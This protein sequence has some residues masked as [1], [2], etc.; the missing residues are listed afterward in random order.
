MHET[1]EM[2][3]LKIRGGRANLLLLTQERNG[4]VLLR[5]GFKDRVAAIRAKARVD[6]PKVGDISRSQASQYKEHVSITT[7]LDTWDRIALKDKD[8][9]V[10]GYPSPSHQWD[11]HRLG[12][13]LL[14]PPWAKGTSISPRALHKPLPLHN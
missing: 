6:H 7:S 9:R 10:M 11:V 13:F 4:G 5:K 14:T 3:V 8:P 12:L 2:R 1:S